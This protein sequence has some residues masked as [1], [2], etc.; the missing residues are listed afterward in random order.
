MSSEESAADPREVV[1]AMLARDAQAAWLGVRILAADLGSVTLGMTVGAA[2]LGDHGLIHGGVLF[3]FADVAM[4]YAAN[5]Y[6]IA[7]LA[8]GANI[9]FVEAGYPGE[10][11]EAVATEHN[12]RGRAGIYDV[13]IRT[14]AGDRLIATF[15]GTTLRVGGSVLNLVPRTQERPA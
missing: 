13:T 15:R 2:H 11:L 5:S 3:T 10:V 6:D 8:T 4:A 14:R 7:A 1:E 12:L 9:S